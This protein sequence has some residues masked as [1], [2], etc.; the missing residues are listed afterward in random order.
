[1]IYPWIKVVHLFAV[2]AWMVGLFYLPRLFVY[3]SQQV[4]GSDADKVFG[5]MERRLLR[6]IMRPAAVVMLLSGSALVHV[7]G[8]GFAD[9]WLL[10]K[11]AGVFGL[12]VM[13]GLMERWAKMFGR[14]ERVHSERFFRIINEVPSILLIWILIWV[15]VRPFS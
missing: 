10:A 11:L 13:H 15:V 14:G 9:R 2:I 7:Q 1:V 3:H 5:V 8:L 6:I 4:A 12:V